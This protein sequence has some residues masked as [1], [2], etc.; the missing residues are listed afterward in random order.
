[1]N[2]HPNLC[3]FGEV[4]G[5]WTLPAK[6][7]APFLKMG[8][9]KTAILN[10]VYSSGCVYYSAQCLS[11][12]AR[13]CKGKTTHFRQRRNIHSIGVKEFFMHL[14]DPKVLSWF[15][16]CEGLSI[17]HLRREDLLARALSVLR[18][19]QDGKA[20][21]SEGTPFAAAI[22]IAP[23]AL[24]EALEALVLEASEERGILEQLNHHPILRLVHEQHMRD[25]DATQNTLR[26]VH[27]FL[28]V[29]PAPIINTGHRSALKGKAIES[30][31][32]REE[33]ERLLMDSE[34]A[35]LLELHR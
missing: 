33:I 5:S 18:L 29:E 19:Q 20:T 26:H 13:K 22:Q 12:V 10:Q 35:Q 4:L 21:S 23:D 16:Q 6:L 1:M 8:T 27:E 24:F 17:L 2:Q 9:P 7:A 25:W 30:V 32:N 15:Q 31:Q 28:G 3:N 11:F 14:R 34:Y